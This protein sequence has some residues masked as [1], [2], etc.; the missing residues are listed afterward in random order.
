MGAG[1]KIDEQLQGT[2]KADPNYYGVLT[3]ALT[4]I[5]TVL[6]VLILL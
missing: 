2:L 6:L 3:L 1:R 4:A 5:N